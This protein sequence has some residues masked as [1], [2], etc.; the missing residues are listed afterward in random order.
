MIRPFEIL[1]AAVA[2]ALLASVSHG[3]TTRPIWVAAGT[4]TQPAGVPVPL[5]PE[6]VAAVQAAWGAT[7]QPSTHDTGV[8]PVQPAVDPRGIYVA[9]GQSWVSALRSARSGQIVY[10]TA[11]ATYSESLQDAGLR[12]NN[13]SLAVSPVGSRATIRVKSGTAL[14]VWQ[15][16]S[17]GIFDIN[18]VADVPSSPGVRFTDGCTG[19]GM[20]RCEV[21][22]FT[23]GVTSEGGKRRNNGV[24]LIDCY[25]HDN[26]HPQNQD[27]SGAFFAAT[28]GI[29]Q[30]G[31]TFDRNGWS[32]RTPGNIRSHN[33]YIA[34]DCGPPNV[35]GNVFSRASSHGLQCR[36]GGIVSGNLFLDNPIHLS[37]GLV[38]GGGPI[39]VGGVIGSVD[40]N[41]FVG[42]RDLAGS[43]RGWAIEVG[44]VKSA[45]IVNNSFA[46]S[47]PVPDPRLGTSPLAIKVDVC[48]LAPT[49][50]YHGRDIRKPLSLTIANNIGT[51]PAGMVWTNGPARTANI[52]TQQDWPSVDVVQVRTRSIARLSSDVRSAVK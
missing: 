17:F 27:G 45:S 38:N 8:T 21:S 28:D 10:L 47:G 13:V 11:G 32:D 3:Q 30:H 49:N 23:F 46:N 12:L 39:V 24:S 15:A 35:T 52:V 33:E 18:F 40:H 26:Y 42:T 51:W 31:C 5:T 43:P 6:V 34:G 9:P 2:L 29:V 20:T 7:T 14:A 50:P 4:T 41:S 36:A 25:I 1:I 19:I 22:G 44:N 16:H 48:N 37:F